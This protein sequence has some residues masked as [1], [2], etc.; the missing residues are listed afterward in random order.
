MG[1]SRHP[2]EYQTLSRQIDAINK[3][4]FSRELRNRMI[5]RAR[6]IW[7]HDDRDEVAEFRMEELL[8]QQPSPGG[9][10]MRL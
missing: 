10:G 7:H 8:W 2:E 9:R 1:S 5:E 3:L 6:A 4:P